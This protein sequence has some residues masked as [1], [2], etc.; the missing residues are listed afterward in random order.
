MRD[1]HPGTPSA[2]PRSSSSPNRPIPTPGPGE[3]LVRVSAA[4]IN[5][6]DAAVR[7]GYYPLLGEPPFTVGWDISGT[8]EAIGARRQR[9]GGRRRGVRHAALPRPGRSLCRR[10]RRAGRRTG[11]EAAGLDHVQAARPAARRPHRLA[12]PG[13]AWRLEQGQRVLIHARPAASAISPCRSPRRAAPMS[14]P[15]QAPTKLDFVRSLGADEVI[16]Y[17]RRISP[18]GR[19][20]IDIALDPIGGDHALQTLKVAEER[21]RAGLLADVSEAANAEAEARAASGSSASRS[22]RSRRA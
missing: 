14:S 22:A 4:G 15:R 1:D 16:D 3:V 17:R 11:A 10:S 21:R 8:V 19:S 13:A 7:G 2:D 5:P 9:L 12:R 6:V 18:R 20:D